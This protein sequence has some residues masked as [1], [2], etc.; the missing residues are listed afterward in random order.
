MKTSDSA[1]PGASGRLTPMMQ[2]YLSTKEENP[3]CLLFFRL[4]DFYELFFD[5]AITASRELEITLTGRD[6]GLPER[7]PMCGVPQKAVTGYLNQLIQKGYKVAICEQLTDPKDSEGI[8]ERGVVRIVTPGTAVEEGL[9]DRDRNHYIVSICHSEKAIGLASADVSTGAFTV[10]ELTENPRVELF[11]ELTRLAPSEMIVNGALKEDAAFFEALRRIAFA[12][13]YADWAFQLDTARK[14]LE[15]HFAVASLA[16]FGCEGMDA[17]VRAAGALMAY[18]N[19]TQKNALAHIG[20]L[21]VETRSHSL[22]LDAVTRRN[23]ELTK[24]L[25]EGSGKRATLFGLLNRTKTAMGARMLRA[26]IDQ[27]LFD[28]DAIDARLDAVDALFRDPILTGSVQESLQEVFDIERLAGKIA[29]ASFNARDALA[30]KRSLAA[31]PAVRDALQNDLPPMLCDLR[32]QID[33]MEDI[34]D[35]LERAIAL[36]PPA[37]IKE[38]GLIKSGYHEQVD[39]YRDASN[40]AE[41]WLAAIEIREREATGIK[42]LRIGFNKVFGYYIEVTKSNL[43]QVPFRFQR[44]QTLANCER[45]ITQEL[46][47]LESQILGAQDKLVAL[48]YELFV[49]LRDLLTGEIARFQQTA[50]AIAQLDALQ[51]LAAS[52][53]EYG[54][55]RPVIHLGDAIEIADGRHPIVERMEKDRF[56]ANDS[57]L[58][59]GHRLMII[60]GPNMAGKSTYMRQVALIAIMAQIG[61][62]VPATSARLPLMDRVFT[63]VGASDNL[64]GGQSTFMVEMTET[65]HILRNATKRSL[66]LLDEI[67]RGTSTFDGLSIAWAVCEHI[68]D[69]VLCG[70]K[71]LFATHYHELS[72]LEGILDGVVNYRITAKEVG[73]GVVF[74]RKVVRGGTD[75]SFGIQVARLAGLPQ[76]VIDRAREILIRLEDADLNHPKASDTLLGFDLVAQAEH[77]ERNENARQ[78]ALIRDVA[79]L[80]TDAM[81]PLEA[82]T[83]LTQLKTQAKE[84]L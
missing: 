60:T 31:L 25:N 62:F 15:T 83:V 49:A 68:A 78:S 72:E 13:S 17:G 22:M 45:F 21:A 19:E 38:G 3:D 37:T 9:L 75:K 77:L 35:L 33:P 1:K 12:D 34:C 50:S 24:P 26:W 11:D 36:D 47:E 43:D 53:A 84:L 44:K 57:A 51:S 40:R 73:D 52:A 23:L 14:N 32:G 18:L 10:M 46:K 39:A 65:A 55:A 81:T 67:G 56:V 74:L 58:D 42:N 5:D 76:S 4:G 28:K 30:L 54:Y 20:K 16:S 82:L 29:Y 69:P 71:T 66:V 7:A 6:C 59:D 61:S 79:N 64:A 48:E 8:V 2:Q 27:P 70:A 41:E 80:E 63:R